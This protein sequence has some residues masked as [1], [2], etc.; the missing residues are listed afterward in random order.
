MQGNVLSWGFLSSFL[1]SSIWGRSQK[2]IG[3]L[4][5][6]SL[7]YWYLSQCFHVFIGQFPKSSSELSKWLDAWVNRA[8]ST[9][10]QFL[11][12]STVNSEWVGDRGTGL[13]SGRAHSPALKWCLG[14]VIAQSWAPGLTLL[15][16]L[17]PNLSLSFPGWGLTQTPEHLPINI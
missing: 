16:P 5:H 1:C 2:W 9:Y 12:L 3:S 6:F 4:Y 14:W 11:T 7:K 17:S 8:R 15:D 10:R 13:I